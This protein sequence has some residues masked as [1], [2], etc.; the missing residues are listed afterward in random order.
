MARPNPPPPVTCP[1]VR[2]FDLGDSD[3]RDLART[4]ARQS[5][6]PETAEA[7]AAAISAYKATEAG[8]ADTTIGNT[9]AALIELTRPAGRGYKRAVRRMSD[10]SSG[11]DDTTLAM[12]QPLAKAVL[13]GKPGATE[14]LS[15]AA[16][17][18]AAELQNHQRVLPRTESLRLFCGVLREIFRH[19]AEPAP[20][21]AWHRCGKFA[22]EV[23]TV[24]D[25]EHADF[26]AH[27]ERLREYL[28]TDVSP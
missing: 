28:G 5:L 22:L 26:I 21:E 27:P 19:W 15:R 20:G 10:E 13:A 18:R 25:V 1:T 2:A 7:I 23:L 9:V 4:L 8:A 12:L 24:A 17:M 6:P 16:R 11:V 3:K 14:S